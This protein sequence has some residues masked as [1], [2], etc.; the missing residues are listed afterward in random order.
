M[1]Y[2]WWMDKHT[3]HHTNPNHDDLD[4]DV[5]PEVLIWATKSARGRRGLKGFLTRHQAGLFFP[6]LTLLGIDLK[7][8]QRQ[9]A[10]STA[11]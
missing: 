6:L 11:R 2:G 4:P 1:S 7:R 3:R 10:A 5:A 9:G 8:G